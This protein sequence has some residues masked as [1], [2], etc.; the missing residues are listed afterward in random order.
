EGETTAVVNGG[1]SAE[2]KDKEKPAGVDEEGAEEQAKETTSPTTTAQ[3]EKQSDEDKQDKK[4]KEKT[5]KKWSFRSISFSKKDKSKPNM[6][7]EDSKTGD[8]AKEQPVAEVIFS[9]S[10]SRSFQPLTVT[11]PWNL[12]MRQAYGKLV[13]YVQSG[14][15]FAFVLYSVISMCRQEREC[16]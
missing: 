9:N 7:R 11:R 6:S 15:N 14:F 10:V 12:E 8:L 4:K 5:K 13:K 2:P 1:T 16:I 3:Q